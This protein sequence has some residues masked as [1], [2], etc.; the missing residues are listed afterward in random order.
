M[1]K[2][3]FIILSFC[4]L[5]NLNAQDQKPEG[6]RS[7]KILKFLLGK[8]ITEA[9]SILLKFDLLNSTEDIQ[10]NDEDLNVD[11]YAFFNKNIKQSEKEDEL[12]FYLACKNDKVLFVS[13]S[14]EFEDEKQ[15]IKV[16]KKMIEQLTNE[17]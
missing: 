1:K 13:L 16:L 11:I 6:A 5:I 7:V 8:T 14:F 3:S 17:S 10:K 4:L 15:P 9:K 2:L 12:M